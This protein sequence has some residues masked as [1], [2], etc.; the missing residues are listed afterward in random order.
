MEHLHCYLS[1]KT[2]WPT[3]HGSFTCGHMHRHGLYSHDWIYSAHMY[4]S[5][6]S[7]F[8]NTFL[9]SPS[10]QAQPAIPVVIHSCLG[11]MACPLMGEDGFPIIV[12]TPLTGLPSAHAAAN[13]CNG[14][15]ASDDAVA[16]MHVLCSLADS[17]HENDQGPIL[18][19]P[20]YPRGSCLLIN[21][22]PAAQ[23]DGLRQ[24]THGYDYC[25]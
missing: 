25:Q 20:I 24:C 17:L 6:S 19:D 8:I 7:V 15:P 1:A 14:I 12:M 4:D 11:E 10:P 2:I 3:V 13:C 5:C 21:S 22:L 16:T 9:M 18:P 23:S